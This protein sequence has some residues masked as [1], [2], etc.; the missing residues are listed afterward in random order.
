MWSRDY[1]GASAIQKDRMSLK[2]AF[3]VIVVQCICVAAGWAQEVR[4]YEENGITYR[5]TRQ[6]VSRPTTEITNQPV[7]R[8][9]YQEQLTTEYQPTTRVYSVPV[10][11][12]RQEAYWRGRWNPFKQPYLDQRIV[13]HTRWEER[14]E[15]VQTPVV[16]RQVVPQTRQEFV[17]VATQRIVEEQYVSR[18]AIG[19]RAAIA[20]NPPSTTSI[21]AATVEQ[22]P[23]VGGISRLDPAPAH[24]ISNSQWRPASSSTRLR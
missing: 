4:Y 6:T 15:T 11:E 17:P 13:S 18:V 19:T 1:S 10:T 8:T 20:A 5:E 22:K 2:A 9:V 21:P 23:T 16:R 14:T 7:D 3:S 12:Y 24:H